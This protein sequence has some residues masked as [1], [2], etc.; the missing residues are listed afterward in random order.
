MDFI[1]PAVIK[2]IAAKYGFVFKKGLGQNFLTSQSVLEDIADA[3]EIEEC[4]VLE[5]GPGF[6]VLT[7]E[8]AKR[9][10]K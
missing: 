10:I 4:G 8:L 9:A 5:V 6:G 3:A 2:K 7:N 1:S